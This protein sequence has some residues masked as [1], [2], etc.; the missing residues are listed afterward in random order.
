MPN[1]FSRGSVPDRVTGEWG[2]G[3]KRRTRKTPEQG[4]LPRKTM[5]TLGKGWACHETGHQIQGHCSSR[6]RLLSAL[7]QLL[8]II[9]RKTVS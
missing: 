9:I 3:K 5:P 4:G 8:Q 1:S 7:S 6:E 2:I